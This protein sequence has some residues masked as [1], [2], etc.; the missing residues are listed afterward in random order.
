MASFQLPSLLSF[1][2]TVS[3]CLRQGDSRFYVSGDDYDAVQA[4]V[5]L[6]WSDG[7]VEGH[8]NPSCS[9]TQMVRASILR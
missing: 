2:W 8:T 7:P 6:P 3:S 5:T 1:H 4:D 9:G